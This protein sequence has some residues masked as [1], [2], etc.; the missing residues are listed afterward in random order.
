VLVPGRALPEQ[1]ALGG[2]LP[3]IH[4]PPSGCHFRTRCARATERCASEVPVLSAIPG[5]QSSACFHPLVEMSR[6]A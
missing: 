3:S 6:S 5:G 4:N 1:E 2:E